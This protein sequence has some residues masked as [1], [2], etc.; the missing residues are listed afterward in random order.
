MR[1]KLTRNII[2]DRS[3]KTARSGIR[4]MVDRSVGLRDLVHLEIGEP[5]FPTPDHIVQAG[6]K[7]LDEEWT[8]YTANRG[9]IDLRRSIA[10]KLEEENGIEA[11]PEREIMVTAGAMQ[12]ISL[13][14]LVTVNPGEEVIVPNPGY[15]SFSRQVTFAGGKPVSVRLREESDGFKIKPDE[16]EEKITS[17][18]KAIVLNTPGNP[19][20]NVITKQELEEIADIA[21]RRELLIFA[22]EIYEKIVF[23][24]AKHCSIASFPGMKE[25]TVS[26]MGLSKTYAMTGWRL[27][28]AAAPKQIVDEM[29]KIQEFYVTCATSISQRAAIVA[30][31]GPQDAV[32]AMVKEYE[33]RRDFLCE[34]LRKIEGISCI[35]PDGAFYVF[36]DISRFGL[37]CEELANL[38]LDKGKVVTTPGTAFGSYGEGHLRLSLATSMED[39][40]VGV[41]RMKEVLSEVHSTRRA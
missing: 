39:L 41:E 32:R 1:R 27:G 5:N 33:G 4:V 40:K 12:A 13:A 31:D 11:D 17:R 7:A 37:K 28:Y 2:A 3:L 29:N 25:R 16:L 26:I 34:E 19:T 8:H 36:P 9:H 38:L 30:L 21:R 24:D 23:G 6:K 18:T 35:R 20:G 14:I 22:D 10:R 15:E